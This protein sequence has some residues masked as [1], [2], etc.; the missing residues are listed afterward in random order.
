MG[1]TRTKSILAIVLLSLLLFGCQSDKNSGEVANK[2]SKLQVVATTSMIADAVKVIASDKVDLYA[3]MGPGV[4]PHLY[5]ATKGDIDN[6]YKADLILFNGL[7]LEAKVAQ[8]MKNMSGDK[9]TVAV[10]ESIDSSLLRHPHEFYGFPDPHVWF[11]VSMWTTVVGEITRAL[12]VLSPENKEFFENNFTIYKDSLEILDNWV[13][14][15][16][17]TIPKVKRVLVT[18]HD[19]FGYFGLAYDIE[20]KGLQGISTVAE[21]GLYDVTAMIDFLTDRKIQGVFVESSISSKSISSVVEGCIARGHNIK[22]G[23]TLF[24]DA[25]GAEGTIEGTYLGMVRHNVNIIVSSLK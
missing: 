10:A 15:Q 4:D 11:D 20:V 6:I 5:K 2:S 3:M 18:A 1:F 13:K 24:S 22:I 8:I 25:M 17:A 9:T 7:N 23:G 21:A 12:V 14:S 16:I 19:A